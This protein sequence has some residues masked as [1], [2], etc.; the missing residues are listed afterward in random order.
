[1][2]K[3]KEPQEAKE[4]P[5]DPAT[6]AKELEG[7]IKLN[8]I[9]LIVANSLFT[10][11]L[12]ILVTGF[13]VIYVKVSALSDTPQEKVDRELEKIN[14]ELEDIKT[15]RESEVASIE[16]FDEKIKSL[17]GDKE[18]TETTTMKQVLLDREK[19]YQHLVD[20]LRNGT[21]SLAGMVPGSRDWVNFYKGEMDT[22]KQHSIRRV[23]SMEST[24][25]DSNDAKAPVT[26][27]DVA[28]SPS[29]EKAVASH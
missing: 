4:E 22:L 27:T 9:L 8:K 17:Q 14:K 13:G 1:M 10:L 2:S 15:F 26:K 12:C 11:V 5:K 21:E 6:L 3:D 7:K 25:P 20:T 16:S 24:L 19:D 29:P 18:S 28:P 23:S